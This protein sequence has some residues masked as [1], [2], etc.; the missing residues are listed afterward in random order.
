MSIDNCGYFKYFSKNKHKKVSSHFTER[1]LFY[2]RQ[3]NLNLHLLI[4]LTYFLK[5]LRPHI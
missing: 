4:D 1:I 2:A 3:D 5:I